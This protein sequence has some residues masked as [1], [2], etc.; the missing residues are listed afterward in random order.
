MCVCS[1]CVCVTICMVGVIYVYI[2]TVFGFCGFFGG[3]GGG[4]GGLFGFFF[5][6]LV[7]CLSIIVW[8]LAV[9]S[10]LYACVL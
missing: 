4:G 3:W 6:C 1:V 5:N 2:D 7:G 10:V 8:T 9:L